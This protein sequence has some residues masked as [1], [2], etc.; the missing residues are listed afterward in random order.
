MA[1]ALGSALSWLR[2]FG[3]GQAVTLLALAMSSYHLIVAHLGEP[4][5]EIHRPVHLFFALSIV[6][7]VVRTGRRGAHPR[8]GLAWDAAMV[9]ATVAASFYLVINVAEVQERMYLVDPLTP[10]QYALAIALVVVVLEATRRTIGW[11]VVIVVAVFLVYSIYG[12]WL[13]YPLWHRGFP[14]A[15]VLETVYL[16]QSS[17]WGVPVAVTASYIFLFVLFG[18]FLV[19]SGAGTFFTDLARALTGRTVGGPAK[20]AVLSSALI[21]MLSGSATAN[22]VTTGSFTIPAMKRAG[23]DPAFAAGVEAVAS[24]GGQFTPPIMGAAA[25]IMM[26][27]TGTPYVRIIAAAAIPAALYFLAVF[28]MVDFEARRARIQASSEEV[29][30]VPRLLRRRGYLVLALAAMLYALI[31]GYTPATSAYWAILSLLALLL[32][33]DRENRR[34]FHRV[35][36]EAMNEAPRVIGSITVACAAG[37]IIVGVISQTGLGQRMSVIVLTLAGD[38]H[39]VLLVLT[40]L[41]ALVLGMGMPTSGAYIILAALLAPGMVNIGIGLLPAHMFIL[42]GAAISSITPPVA[43]ASYAAAAIANSDPWRT[44][45]LAFRLGLSSFI[46]PFMFVYGPALLGYGSAV[47]IGLAAASASV[48]VACLSA[49]I[50]GWLFAPLRPWERGGL[51]AAALFLIVPGLITDGMGILIAGLVGLR[52]LR[53]AARPGLAPRTAAD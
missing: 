25:F 9:A 16:S 33:L 20:T 48:G 49:A 38:S 34:R 45:L 43:V 10:A 8:L 18:S 19:A 15:E 24:S 3:L 35:C 46:I 37:G 39:L 21:G 32:L 47:E 30:S 6:F 26:E 53:R 52:V 41:V 51:F 28:C 50:I 7:L 2:R 4:V 31:E 27:I 11:A 23:Y 42:Y 44:S 29:P 12:N 22:V 17:V 5:A 1:A 14:L 13:P 36:F 40:M